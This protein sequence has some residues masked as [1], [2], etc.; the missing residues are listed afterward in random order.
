MVFDDDKALTNLF[1]NTDRDR[2][3][4]YIVGFKADG[5]VMAQHGET[6]PPKR[7]RDLPDNQFIWEDDNLLNIVAPVKKGIQALG[8]LQ[9]GF[10]TRRISD[11]SWTFRKWALLLA[12]LELA[13]ALAMALVLGKSF[14]LLFTQLRASL[15]RTAQ[16]VEEV[17]GQLGSV[18]AEQTAAAGEGSAALHETSATVSKVSEA[19]SLAAE[20]ASALTEGGHRAEDAGTAGLSAMGSAVNGMQQVREQMSTIA[21]AV[22]ALSERAAAIGDIASTVAMLAERSNLLALNAAIEAARAGAQGRGFSVVAQE[23]RSLADGSNRSASQVKAIINEIQAAITRAVGDARE[24]ERRVHNAEE[25]ADHAGESIRKFA[26]VTRDFA[27]LGKEIATSAGQQ[28]AAIEQIVESIGHATQAGN[29]PLETTKQVE[30]TTRQL[31][32]LSRELLQSV[33]GDGA[34]AFI[35]LVALAPRESRPSA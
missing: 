9:M 1:L 10:S 18:A 26:A 32:D 28:S 35:R 29:T 21:T 4:A 8:T 11:E 7:P 24:G 5:K 12:A 33:V 22:A 23:M 17:V 20:R 16:S 27:L 2:E 19:A 3:L 31:R 13:V 14:M 30:A 34:D 25:L 6:T 15:T